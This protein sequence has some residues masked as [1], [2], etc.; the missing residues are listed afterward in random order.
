M[1]T[2]E[3]GRLPEWRYR[4]ISRPAAPRRRESE[5]AFEAEAEGRLAAEGL[6]WCF[7]EMDYP[8]WR[9]VPVFTGDSRSASYYIDGGRSAR[10]AALDRLML[11]ARCGVFSRCHAVTMAK[12]SVD[13]SLAVAEE[14]EPPGG[15]RPHVTADESSAR[16]SDA[17]SFAVPCAT[18]VEVLR[19]TFPSGACLTE[20][21]A[22]R[23]SHHGWEEEK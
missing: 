20:V 23:T 1:E 7:G 13:P 22:V 2:Q 18:S 15:S 14:K 21:R 6:P 10:R 12:K 4:A 8:H 9:R 3:R 11:C 5:D 17:R 19:E 16:A